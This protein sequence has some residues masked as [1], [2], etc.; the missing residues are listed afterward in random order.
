MKCLLSALCPQGRFAEHDLS[1]RIAFWDRPI[2]VRPGAALRSV[3]NLACSTDLA[4]P[5]AQGTTAIALKL[6]NALLASRLVTIPLWA[7]T[8]VH[9]PA[10]DVHFA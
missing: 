4:P 9:D 1:R 10:A 8:I 3:S 5:P 7:V 2:I 6:A